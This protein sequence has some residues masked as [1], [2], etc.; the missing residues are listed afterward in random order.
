MQNAQPRVD[1]ITRRF[2]AIIVTFVLIVLCLLA[3]DRFQADVLSAVRA[4]V[5][6]EGLYSK[7]QKD[8]VYY[9]QAYA[10]S[11]NDADY[12]RF[13]EA[14][15]VPLGD[16]RA[17][18]AL[19]SDPPDIA[20][21]Q[22]GLLAGRNDPADVQQLI[23]F[24]L[25][26]RFVPEMQEAIRIWAAADV[27]ILHLQALGKRMH[28]TITRHPED[29]TSIRGLLAEVS[30][31]ADTV[32]RLE[33]DFSATLG[34]AA[35]RTYSFTRILM[36]CATLSLLLI[37][38][39]VSRRILQTTRATQAQLLAS[40]ARFR[41]V[42]ESNII[43]VFFWRTGGDIV[44][45]ND[46][47]LAMLGY[48][49][50]EVSTL[51][52]RDIS[53]PE[54]AEIDNAASEQ[55]H[56]LGFVDPYEKVFFRKDGSRVEALVGAAAFE[57]E[58]DTGFCIV[59]D[60]TEQHRLKNRI[61]QAQKMEAI[62]TLVGGI[63]H[64]FNNTLTAMLGNVQLARY[65]E[66]DTEALATRFDNLEALAR[67]SARIVHQLMTF[68]RKDVMHLT[69]MVLNDFMREMVVRAAD[70]IPRHID[71]RFDV[72]DDRLEVNA[73]PDLLE[74][75]IMHVL[76]NAR[77]A[78]E[79]VDSP[80]I[81]CTLQRF[82]PGPVDQPWQPS[83]PRAYARIT[84]M[85]NGCGMSTEARERVFEP[86]FTTHDVGE[87]MGLGMSMAYGAIQ[88][89]DG[90][91]SVDSTPTVGTTI[92]IDLPL[93]VAKTMPQPALQQRPRQLTSAPVVLLVDDNEE[94]R[95]ICTEFLR[96]SGVEVL[97][98]NDG[99]AAIACFEDHAEEIQLV[100]TD[101][102]MPNLGGVKLAERLHAQRPDL[103]II[104]MTGYDPHQAL[105][106]EVHETQQVL[107]KPFPF[108]ELVERVKAVL[109]VD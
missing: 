89:H 6:G 90:Q 104:F 45:A 63:A 76:H 44:D 8:A 60:L 5:A 23:S 106:P 81:R 105:P 39:L 33:D 86:F 51:N 98:E 53:S 102:A 107:V 57:T 80:A 41:H 12:A 25:N 72:T 21:A 27:H 22:A 2:F 97:A 109:A 7:S 48:S 26:F 20:A 19:Q 103:P 62:G 54:Y 70:V 16:H 18:L 79:G 29:G 40:E 66:N 92:T 61:E 49:R 15:A 11:H 101:V 4:Y 37:G 65:E 108:K 52:W 56:R 42:V 9:L 1:G 24:F 28:E 96:S 64:D 71:C 84:V 36:L 100:I 58:A 73:D 14:L 32:S 85:D 17:R 77:S 35:R 3:L 88:S 47:F 13:N 69:P 87:G 55:V 43:G 31:E 46:A 99:L 59:L 74:Q 34:Q 82:E 83:S 38:I 95:Q 68:A 91:I 10:R 93:A 94:L 67:H 75:V 78:V 30:Q 50:D